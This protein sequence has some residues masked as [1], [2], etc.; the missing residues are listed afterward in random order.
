MRIA[1]KNKGSRRGRRGRKPQK[2]QRPCREH[3]ETDS[4]IDVSDIQANRLEAKNSSIRRTN[5]AFRRKTNT[6]AK[7]SMHLQRT[8]DVGWV[9][10]NFAVKHFTTGVVPA[11]ALAI[12]DRAFKIEELLMIQLIIN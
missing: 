10:R 6:Y 4:H 5:S 7:A 12:T 9:L 3:P 1:R 11:V 2:Y 8:L